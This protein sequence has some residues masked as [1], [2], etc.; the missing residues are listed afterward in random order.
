MSNGHRFYDIPTLFF[1][2]KGKVNDY[3]KNIL[4]KKQIN[5]PEIENLKKRYKINFFDKSKVNCNPNCIVYFDG[6][7]LYSDEDHWSYDSMKYFGKKLDEL[8]FFSIISNF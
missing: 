5:I 4:S 8:E 2:K 3:A 1:K 7:L 6:I